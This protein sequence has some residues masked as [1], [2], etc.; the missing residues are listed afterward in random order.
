MRNE[1]NFEDV[2]MFYKEENRF[3]HVEMFYEKGKIF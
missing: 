2:K 1:N 3:E